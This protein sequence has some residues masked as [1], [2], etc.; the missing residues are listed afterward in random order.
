[1]TDLEFPWLE[2]L[3]DVA[4]YHASATALA[5]F[6]NEFDDDVAGRG[7]SYRTAQA[8]D[9]GARAFG[10]VNLLRAAGCGGPRRAVVVDVFGGDGLVAEIWSGRGGTDRIITADI[11][12]A[13]VHAARRRGWP[14]VRQA[15]QYMVFADAA[16]DAV[17][18]AYGT[19]HLDG[20]ARVCAFA[21]AHRVLRPG[22]RLVVHDFDELS[23]MAM[24]FSRIVH[25]HTAAGHPYGLFNPAMLEA[26]LKEAGF[27]DITI[28]PSYDPFRVVRPSPGSSRLALAE[29]LMRMYGLSA[30]VASQ[31]TGLQW[32]LNECTAIFRLP[33]TDLP[34]GA[35]DRLTVLRTGDGYSAELPRMALVAVATKP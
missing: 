3:V 25:R 6:H 2:E 34:L 16:V 17:L 30:A 20:A 14:A 19:H 11:S 9:R 12:S 27:R 8:K 31:P 28:G 26:M 7:D 18:M 35:V 29:H 32:L 22:G 33:D 23:P 21:E 15:A 5:G 1:M 24:W 10:V 4:R 13:M